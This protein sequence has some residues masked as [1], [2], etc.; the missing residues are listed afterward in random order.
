MDTRSQVERGA[1]EVR[2]LL[3]RSQAALEGSS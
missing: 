1:R 3:H 2:K